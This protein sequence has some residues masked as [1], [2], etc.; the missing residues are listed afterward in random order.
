MKQSPKEDSE[1]ISSFIV[2]PTAVCGDISDQGTAN[3]C[4]TYEG[5]TEVTAFVHI[6]LCSG[7]NK[8]NQ[9]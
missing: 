3:L 5:A 7:T 4:E 6:C 1:G 8:Q 2:S 9:A